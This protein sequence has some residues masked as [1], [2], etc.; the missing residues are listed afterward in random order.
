MRN[1]NQRGGGGQ[2]ILGSRSAGGTTLHAST[3]SAV[4]R[5]LAQ[6]GELRRANKMRESLAPLRKAAEID[7]A[8]PSILHD[9]GTTC[10][11]LGRVVE[12]VAALRRA[13]ECKPTFAHAHFRLGLGLLRLGQEAE[14]VNALQ[15]AVK[16]QPSLSEAQLRLGLLLD[17]AG[18][19]KEASTAFKKAASHAKNSFL[20]DFAE[21]R[22]GLLADRYD[23]AEKA[24]RRALRRDPNHA[25]AHDLLGRVLSDQGRFQDAFASFA[26]ALERAP[27]MTGT[28]Y[29][30]VRCR[31]ITSA[32]ADLVDRMRAAA[33]D[34]HAADAGKVKLLLALGKALD[35]LADHPEAM[36]AFDAADLCR[37][38]LVEVDV[39]AIERRVDHLVAWFTPGVVTRLTS[40]NDDRTPVLILGM[41]RSGTT[42]VEHIVSSH[43]AVASGDE[44]PFWSRRG[45]LMEQEGPAGLGEDFIAQAG[46]D[47][48]R[49]LDERGRAGARMTDKDPFN[50]FW[51][52]LIH[53]AFPKAT[54]IH[55]RRPA[56]DTALSIHQTYFHPRLQLPTGGDDLVRYL[57]AYERLMAHWRAV[58]PPS[59]LIDVD[60][61]T[62][63]A[64]P[65]QETRR[66]IDAVGLPWDDACLTPERNA[67]LVKSA[68]KW[69]VRQPVHRGSNE[70]WRRYKD[71]LGPLAQLLP[72]GSGA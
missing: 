27:A 47:Y 32:D 5:L 68:S 18:R 29:D 72:Q 55:C 56:V 28:Y 25:V 17:D 1:P 37:R 67:R 12:A 30:M 46:A 65:E 48:I 33:S 20:G 60:Y 40:G 70:R 69:Q 19:R 4:A 42:L 52:G 15:A 71:V 59:V 53:V 16:L 49:Y 41:P 9:L 6:A 58:I 62:L 61:E 3:A 54:I 7:G 13:I 36:A 31:K 43:P 10:L 66:I 38:T 64:S 24:L 63:T 45:A 26:T 44:L 21:A 2:V 22:V 8:N 14:A 57:R 11:S 23:D 50:F 39:A 34:A 51:V 35:D